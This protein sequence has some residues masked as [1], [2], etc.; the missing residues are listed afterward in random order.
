M[1]AFLPNDFLSVEDALAASSPHAAGRSAPAH[2][3]A[4]SDYT[5][6]CCGR[7]QSE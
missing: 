2:L 6:S 7:D 3:L 4:D 5:D 1:L